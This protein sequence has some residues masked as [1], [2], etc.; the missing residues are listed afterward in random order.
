MIRPQ[1]RLAPK[2]GKKEVGVPERFSVV[3]EAEPHAPD[4]A[5][6]LPRSPPLALAAG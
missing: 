6:A 5:L 2:E 3:G 1:P 4:R